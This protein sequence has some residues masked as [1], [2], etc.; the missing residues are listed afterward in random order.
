MEAQPTKS[1]SSAKAAQ[2][3]QAT[4]A[5]AKQMRATVFMV[6][7]SFFAAHPFELITLSY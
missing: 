3:T 6:N 7:A 2:A 5:S 1:L 4:P